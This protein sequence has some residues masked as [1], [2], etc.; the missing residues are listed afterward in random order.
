M[1]FLRSFMKPY[2]NSTHREQVVCGHGVPGPGVQD[3]DLPDVSALEAAQLPGHEA[4]GRHQEV[5]LDVED[6]GQSVVTGRA[7]GVT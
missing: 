6:G 5:C 4:E 1:E 3:A 7:L 2:I